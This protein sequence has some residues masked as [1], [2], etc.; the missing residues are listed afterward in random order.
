M[1]NF[2]GSIDIGVVIGAY[3]GE[4]V[5]AILPRKRLVGYSFEAAAKE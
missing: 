3:I 5:C 2:K 1:K 4:L